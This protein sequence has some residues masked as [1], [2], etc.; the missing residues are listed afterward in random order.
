MTL[1]FD[2]NKAIYVF[3]LDVSIEVSGFLSVFISD[4]VTSAKFT[5]KSA[6]K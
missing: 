6:F 5:V 1:S 3:L 2:P 4:F